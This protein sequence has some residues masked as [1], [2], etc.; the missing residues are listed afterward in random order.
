M[1]RFIWK[2]AGADLQILVKSGS[3]SQNNFLIVGM[4]YLLVNA[5]VFYGFFGLFNSIFSSFYLGL[6]IG[7][8]LTFLISNIYRINMMS[9][10]PPSLPIPRSK[11]SVR[12]A[13]IIRY[14][15]ISMFA[16]F[17]SKL[18]ETNLL[19]QTVDAVVHNEVV[20]KYQ[21]ETGIVESELYFMH[22]K[23]IMKENPLLWL[24]TLLVL[25]I[26]IYPVY[27]K[28][29]LFGNQEYFR[30]KYRID[31]NLVEDDYAVAMDE[32]DSLHVKTYL[33]YP[34]LKQN[35]LIGKFISNDYLL[36]KYSIQE[37]KY[38]DPPF[39]TRLVKKEN[40]LKSHNDFISLDWK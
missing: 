10:D 20:S 22:L 27:L 40:D 24:L 19:Y 16:I 18:V 23:L 4:F 32:L 38:Q 6:I 9:L 11:G 12:A 1:K 28:R 31:K 7:F 30:I 37:N 5:C 15:M 21:N 2:I 26:F 33:K 34:A 36:K 35:E 3:E 29:K 25:Y 14:A 13:V 17:V 8:V 39:N